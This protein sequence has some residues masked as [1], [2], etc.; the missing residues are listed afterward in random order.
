MCA[1]KGAVDL[2]LT[3]A[4]RGS[5]KPVPCDGTVVFERV[6]AGALVRLKV[7]GRSGAPGMIAWR[8]DKA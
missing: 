5:R 2:D 4:G 1:G 3:P 7:Q 6:T 8:V